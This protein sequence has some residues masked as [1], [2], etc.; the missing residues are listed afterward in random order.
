MAD[1]GTSE[2]EQIEIV[3]DMG[4][5]KKMDI[6]WLKKVTRVDHYN[7]VFMNPH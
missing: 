4:R 6:S 5:K 1:C 7:P 3:K 2:N